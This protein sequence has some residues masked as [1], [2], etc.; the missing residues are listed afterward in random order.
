MLKASIYGGEPHSF[1]DFCKRATPSSTNEISASDL[2]RVSKRHRADQ[3]NLDSDNGERE[4][5][6][7]DHQ[8]NRRTTQR[9]PRR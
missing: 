1:R 6:G 9:S 5:K 2:D 7:S 3:Y 4:D 8:Q